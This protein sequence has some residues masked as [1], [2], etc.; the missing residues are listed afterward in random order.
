MGVNPAGH[1]TSVGRDSLLFFVGSGVQDDNHSGSMRIST[2]RDK[3]TLEKLGLPTGV[4]VLNTRQWSMLS[5]EE[6]GAMAEVLGIEHIPEGSMGE[7]LRISGI[8][9]LTEFRVGTLFGFRKN[10]KARMTVLFGMGENLPCVDMAKNLAEI[11]ENNGVR[12]KAVGAALGL[13][14][15]TGFVYLVVKSVLEMRF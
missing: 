10:G 6:M 13:R 11:T 12:S 14:G 2:V 8:P 15:Q 3:P 9:G 4:Q 1:Q 5:E 7:N